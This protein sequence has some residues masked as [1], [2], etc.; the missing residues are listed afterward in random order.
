MPIYEYECKGCSKTFE[1]LQ[2]ANERVKCPSCGARR[3]SKL[4]SSFS[5]PTVTAGLKG[6]ASEAQGCTS[7][8]C[9]S[10]ACPMSGL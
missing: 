2:R 7:D 10:G 4:L 6:C 3:L 8:R 9:E 1:I 5:S